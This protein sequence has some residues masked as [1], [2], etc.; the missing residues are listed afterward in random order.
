MRLKVH[1][2]G[3]LSMRMGWLR[4][5]DGIEWK[6]FSLMRRVLAGR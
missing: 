1:R 5:V 2:S 3:I 4:S 6:S